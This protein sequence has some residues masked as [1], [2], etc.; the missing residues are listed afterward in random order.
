MATFTGKDGTLALGAVPT[1]ISQMSSWTLETTAEPVESS[2]IGSTWRNYKA[3]MQGYSLS[4]EGY[5]D[6]TDTGA[7]ELIAGA[8]VAFTLHPAGD[9]SPEKQYDGSAY[10][11]AYSETAAFDGMVSF[12]AS[13]QGNGALVETAVAV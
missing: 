10:V 7:A 6:V 9:V 4:V 1:A 12:S 13:L 2:V 5:Y 11:T 8:E 3:A